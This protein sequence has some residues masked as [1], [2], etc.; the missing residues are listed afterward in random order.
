MV[1]RHSEFPLL[2]GAVLAGGADTEIVAI[3]AV[4]VVGAGVDTLIVAHDHAA[5]R[6]GAPIA[7]AAATLG[8]EAAGAAKIDTATAPT[9]AIVA[10]RANTIH[11]G[12][13][14]GVAGIETG[15][16][17]RKVVREHDAVLAA[18]RV[19]AGAALVVGTPA[20]TAV[21][22]LI[23]LAMQFKAGTSATVTAVVTTSATGL[24]LRRW[25]RIAL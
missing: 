18:N 4:V 7:P 5:G 12:L 19:A 2:T 14:V 6:A 9:A 3:A 11:A 15:A 17:V 16:A 1:L 24:V 20:G 21:A 25:W 22:A 8:T 23:A 13:G 10:T